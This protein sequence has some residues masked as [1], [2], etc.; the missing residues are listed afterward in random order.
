M[1]ETIRHAR[2]TSPIGELLLATKGDRLCGL[3]MIDDPSDPRLAAAGGGDAFL[4]EIRQQLDA[5]FEGR[6][7]GFQTPLLQD[8]TAFQ[9]KVWA[10]L[11]K[12]PY[13]ETI[14]YAE[15][16]RRVGDPKASRAVGG[17][18][19]RN[20]IAVIVPC[21]RVIAADG[22]LG[23]FGGGLDRKLWLLQHEAHVVGR[24]AP[25]LWTSR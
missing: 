5:Y 21:H 22:R 6:S 7:R 24:E 18:N 2:Y 14:S 1:I 9:R 10:E 11:A 16:A 13:G 15:L 23:G 12:V 19:G 20:P 8:G 17:A 3:H 4:D 25:A